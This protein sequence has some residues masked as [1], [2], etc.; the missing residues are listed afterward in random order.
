MRKLQTIGCLLAA[1]L[2][3]GCIANSSS[4]GSTS[5]P[6][7]ASGVTVTPADA[8]VAAGQTQQFKASVSGNPNAAFVWQ[9]NGVTGGKAGIGTIST[10]GVYT[11]PTLPPTGGKVTVTA[12]AKSDS[13][14]KGS[15]TATIQYSNAS[16]QGTWVFT[17]R[18]E[19]LG[20]IG[21]FQADGKGG[22][23][24]GS[25]DVNAPDGV[26]LKLPFDG[27]YTVAADGTGEA[28]FVSA[29]G[30]ADFRFV[31]GA[32]GRARFIRT[33]SGG[34]GA[35]DMLQQS[36]DV[37]GDAS[38]SGD[39]V[40]KLTDPR[41]AI[42]GRFTADGAGG[43]AD[44]VQDRNTAGAVTTGIPFDAAYAVDDAGRGTMTLT[45]VFGTMHY[46]F[47]VVAPGTIRLL[48][49]DP[50][51]VRAGRALAQTGTR[52]DD[53]DL[54]GDYAFYLAGGTGAATAGLL[55]AD[56]AG[57]IDSGEFDSS[58]TAAVQPVALTGAYAIDGTGRGTARLFTPAGETDLIFYL[59]S[60]DRALTIEADS[61]AA[62]DG[63]FLAQSDDTFSESSLDGSFVLTSGANATTQQTVV[64]R[65][66]LDGNGNID[67]V[68]AAAAGG[69]GSTAIAL[70]G[71]YTLG[72]DGRGTLTLLTEG[73]GQQN[74][75]FYAASSKNLLLV[76]FNPA[77]SA[78][79]RLR[80]RW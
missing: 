67:G 27:N 6:P 61:A 38:V 8:K 63:Q 55:H 21:R 41:T 16:L 30:Q 73:G 29:R 39:Y 40:F 58:G 54:T 52:F 65:I 23:A 70:D 22:I 72:K 74:F 14:A 5:N 78:F 34:A 43:I 35:G 37:G 80:E 68:E 12:I 7:P 77:A 20:V 48:S 17:Y 50:A 56:G 60:A 57:N 76:G 10:D 31:I 47:Y 26:F 71:S 15:A 66:V 24:A 44:A 46:V 42:V 59:Q 2:L 33:D 11:A 62:R 75:V 3:A 32:S 13:T 4:S 18:N 28:V 49:V 1:A 79:T 45:N 51:Q 25:E 64:G 36:A 69:S 9:V 19:N 53:S